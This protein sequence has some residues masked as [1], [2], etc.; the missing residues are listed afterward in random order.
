MPGALRKN[1]QKMIES[2]PKGARG[3]EVGTHEGRATRALIDIAAPETLI[4]IDP[5]AEDAE[6]DA[7]PF[8]YTADQATRDAQFAAVTDAF[9]QASIV[10]LPSTAALNGLRDASLDW[11]W[12]DGNKHYDVVLADLEQAVRVVRPGGIIGGGG[13]HWGKEMGRPVREAVMDIAA[14]LDGAIW[15]NE[16][17]FWT[18]SLPET[19]VLQG[20]PTDERF[21]IISTMK[22]ESPYILEWIAHHRAIGFTDFLVFTNDCD[23]TTDPLLDRLEEVS[24][25][26]GVLTHQVNTVLQ[27]G[28]HKSALKWARDHVLLHKATWI[29]IA[30]VD[31]FINVKLEDRTIQALMRH[32]G[33]ETDV[34]S[35]PWK[36][37]GNGGVQ[38][39]KDKPL[40][41]QFHIC[42]KVPK[43]GGRT[44]RDVKTMFR[45]PEAM[46]HFGL[47]RPRVREDWQDRIVWKSPTGADI[48]SRMNKGKTWTMPWDGC[49]DAA[50][51]HHYPLRSL[52]SYILKK[53]R[54]RANHIN[55]DLGIDYWDKWNMSGGRDKSLK[56]GAPGFAEILATLRADRKIRQLHKQG[57]QWH[58]DQFQELMKQPRYQA[59]WD[60][61]KAR[62]AQ[63]G[64]EKPGNAQD[65]A[66]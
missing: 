46:Y 32:L 51:Q 63:A 6:Q 45:K 50:Y 3:A 15:R 65:D 52:E 58:R 64:H 28:P 11:L 39:F 24:P 8:A 22:N 66:A 5:W 2:F 7:R 1:G 35:F 27:R 23:D 18:L 60:E 29:L 56:D 53:N 37:F 42:E 30:D 43:R 59:L 9:P 38:A 34:V 57:V 33:P 10:R 48:S 41:A 19:V 25:A 17:Q 31:E 12:L 61:L 55:E 16:G 47:H 49:Q 36:I 14:R 44:K 62:E 4:L 54:G 26:G 20:R 21:L 13:F 40:T